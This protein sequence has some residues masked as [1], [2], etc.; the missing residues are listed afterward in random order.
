MSKYDWLLFFH[1]AGAFLL[2]GGSVTAVAFNLSALRRDRPSEIAVL[3]GL[4]RVAVLAVY[5]GV[6]LTIV[7]GVIPG[8]I[9]ALKNNRA[10]G[11]LVVAGSIFALCA[12]AFV[13]GVFLLYLFAIQ[14][15]ILPVSGAGSGF[16]DGLRHLTLPAVALAL[17]ASA[18]ILRHTRASMLGVLNQ[19]YVFAEVNQTTINNQVTTNDQQ[20][21]AALGLG[22]NDVDTKATQQQL[23]I[24]GGFGSN[25]VVRVTL[26]FNT[27][28][29]PALPLIALPLPTPRLP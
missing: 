16:V 13:T 20:E 27:F 4:T 18:F 19:D 6:L 21:A 28:A 26:T 24:N 10:V 22:V 1:V 29:I 3:L 23:S 14:W 25:D 2:I 5:G 12:P 9:A 7:F 8:I 11:K 17:P 15:P